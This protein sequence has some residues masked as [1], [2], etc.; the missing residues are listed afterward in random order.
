MVVRFTTVK[1][2]AAV[3]PN[4]TAVAPLRFVPVMVTAVPPSVLPLLGDTET[5]VGSDCS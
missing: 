5:T 1:L 3:P 2:A 4:L